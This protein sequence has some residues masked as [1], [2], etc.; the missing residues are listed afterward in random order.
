MADQPRLSGALMEAAQFMDEYG[1]ESDEDGNVIVVGNEDMQRLE[2]S[3]LWDV[4]GVVS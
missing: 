1:R 4:E 2:R 3:M